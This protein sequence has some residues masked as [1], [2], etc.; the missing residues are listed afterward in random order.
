MVAGVSIVIPVLNDRQGLR[1]CLESIFEQDDPNDLIAEI[2]VCDGGSADGTREVAAE[3]AARDG[4]VRLLDNPDRTVPFA[5]NRAIDVAASD[6]IVR[7]DS[8]A[9]LAPSYVKS[10]VSVLEETGADVVGGAMRPN[11]SSVMSKAVAWAMDSP[12]G[13][14]GADFRDKDRDGPAESVYMGVFPTGTFERYGRFDTKFTRNQD[15]EFNYRVRSAGGLVFLSSALKSSYEPRG[16]IHALA[17]QF[18][19]YGL[20]KPAVL[21]AHRS[22][23]RPR[24]LAP[25]AAVLA[26]LG[27]LLAPVAP[28]LA[29]PAGLHVLTVAAVTW[30]PGPPTWA[31]RF[32]AV[33]TMHL[34]YG[35]GFLLSA[36]G[37]SRASGIPSG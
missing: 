4:R 1:R 10:S 19:G 23:I 26:W 20:Y 13:A 22:S 35:A 18:F 21:R 24:H 27:L 15:D 28:L 3:A 17:K 6:V 16:S 11:G 2:L 31:A 9:T 8:H 12:I 34:S 32:V 7:V 36:T 30:A 14:G 33:L 25:S 5:L 29:V 37:L